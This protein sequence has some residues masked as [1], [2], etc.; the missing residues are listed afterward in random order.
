MITTIAKNREKELVE[1]FVSAISSLNIS[2]LDSILIDGGEFHFVNSEDE[3]EIGSKDQFISWMQTECSSYSKYVEEGAELEYQLDQ[4]L[5]C[6]IGAVVVLFEDG[7]F[8]VTLTGRFEKQ[9]TGFMLEFKDNGIS[10][11][12]FCYTF[13]RTENKY[14]FEC[15]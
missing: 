13:L 2:S 8:P 14:R 11:I 5:H 6:K 15:Q 12:T 7:L 4:C 9:K 3:T 1:K 10:D